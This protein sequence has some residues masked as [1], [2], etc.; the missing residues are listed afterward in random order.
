MKKICDVSFNLFRAKEQF[1][2][3]DYS[4]INGLESEWYINNQN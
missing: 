4:A 2:D 3:Y 1:P